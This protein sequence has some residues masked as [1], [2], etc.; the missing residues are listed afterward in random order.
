[1]GTNVLFRFGSVQMTQDAVHIDSLADGIITAKLQLVPQFCLA[2]Q[3]QRH[4]AFRVEPVVQQEPE[5]LN[6]FLLQQ[7]RLVQ[8]TDNFLLVDSQEN[9]QF[10]L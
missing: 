4:G 8:N 6:G 1:M 9:L 5:F 3:H 10:L 2:D 7:M